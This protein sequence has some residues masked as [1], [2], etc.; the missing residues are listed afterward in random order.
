MDE[1]ERKDVANAIRTKHKGPAD[2]VIREASPDEVDAAFNDTSGDRG[3]ALPGANKVNGPGGQGST[4]GIRTGS[5]EAG[6]GIDV[7]AAENLRIRRERAAAARKLAA[8]GTVAPPAQTPASEAPVSPPLEDW[9]RE[10]FAAELPPEERPKPLIEIARE[11]A[12]ATRPPADAFVPGDRLAVATM[13]ALAL[14]GRIPDGFELYVSGQGLDPEGV[15]LVMGLG[16]LI[17]KGYAVYRGDSHYRI[18]TAGFEAY[19]RGEHGHA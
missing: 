14:L 15:S 5:R 3:P 13:D 1:A 19:K 4:Q 10:A 11:A 9:E 8:S 12:P 6:G 18:T 2:A 7:K 16:F 17:G